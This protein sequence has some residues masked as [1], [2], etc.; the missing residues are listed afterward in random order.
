[1]VHRK[2]S[3]KYGDNVY[4]VSYNQTTG[5]KI[6]ISLVLLDRARQNDA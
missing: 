4:G 5:I 3:L 2:L 6:S 1:M